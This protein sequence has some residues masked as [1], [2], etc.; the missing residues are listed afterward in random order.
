VSDKNKTHKSED[1][2][3]YKRLAETG[4]IIGHPVTIKG[5]HSRSDN[6]I[7]YHS[8][9]KLLT[10]HKDHKEAHEIASKH[11][12]EPPKPEHTGIEPHTFKDRYGNDVHVL[13]LYGIGATQMKHHND[14]FKHLGP[15]EAY[16]YSPHIS[17]DHESWKKIKDS[18]AK[19]AKEAGIEFGPATIKRGH[20]IL[21][22]YGKKIEKSEFK[23]LMKPWKSKAQARWGHSAAG[24]EALGGEA[25]VREWDVAT[26]GKKLPEKVKKTDEELDKSIARNIGTALSIAGASIGQHQ[27]N[28]PEAP[29]PAV[30][31]QQ[32]APKKAS[33]DHNKMLNAISSVESNKGKYT[34]HKPVEGGM[35]QGSSAVGQYGLMPITIQETVKMNPAL[36]REHSKILGM[37]G[38]ELHNYMQKHPDLEGKI[39][40]SYLSRLEHHFGQDPEKIGF[41]WFQGISAGHKAIKE[42]KPISQHFHVKKIRAAYDREK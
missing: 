35:H 7:P 3:T 8:T 4:S 37:K 28:S 39:A 29:K 32:V 18:G 24:E 13:K 38:P 33:Y 1:P 9:I 36:K 23:P 27:A 31:Q 41:S 15:K 40:H 22:T 11:D 20:K 26:H 42:N 10:P 2:E 6:G 5:Q 16:D 34:H 14:H 25:G 30:Q 12:L 21:G 17:L 19:T